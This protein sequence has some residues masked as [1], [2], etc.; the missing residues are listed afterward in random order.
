MADNTQKTTL[1]VFLSRILATVFIFGANQSIRYSMRI[2]PLL[3]ILFFTSLILFSACQADRYKLKGAWR[4]K[5]TVAASDTLATLSPSEAFLSDIAALPT[6]DIEVSFMPDDRML[7]R[8]RDSTLFAGKPLVEGDTL[9][10]FSA[11]NHE[12]LL[13]QYLMKWNKVTE[14]EIHPVPASSQ[15]IS[16]VLIKR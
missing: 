8:L 13:Y 11:E 15:G 9:S 16:W 4:I 12:Q 3:P 2:T 7:L 5:S 10:V 6:F 14:V 1:P